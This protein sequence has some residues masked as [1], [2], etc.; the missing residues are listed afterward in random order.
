MHD[1]E[2]YDTSFSLL[3]QLGDDSHG[4]AWDRLVELYSPLLR[5]WLG[6]YAVQVA[7]MDDLVQ[8]VLL[9]L[10]REL[11]GFRHNQRAGAFR[12]WLRQILVNRL[13]DF[14]RSRQYRPMAT[15][16]SDIQRQ[17]D[18]LADDGSG[19]SQMWNREHD[20]FVMK[21]LLESVEPQFEPKTWLAFRRQ[22]VEG[23]RAD[24]V[25]AELSITLGAVYMAK[26]RVLNAL[27]RESAGLIDL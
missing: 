12:S 27:R 6:R 16:E 18:S 13:R 1:Q 19:V 14:W 7:D 11:P 5:V 2:K 21:K 25:A 24:T 17:L 20:A 10:M 23:V 26:S 22:V 15:G 4:A 9:V 3:E 8:D